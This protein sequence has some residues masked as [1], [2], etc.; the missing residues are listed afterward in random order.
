MVSTVQ[1][2]G[3]TPSLLPLAV[4]LMEWVWLQQDHVFSFL[5]ELLSRQLPSSLT[6]QLVDDIILSRA[7]VIKDIC[8]QKYV[9]YTV[10]SNTVDQEIFVELYFHISA[11]NFRHLASILHF[12]DEAQKD[13]LVCGMLVCACHGP[14]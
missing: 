12:V 1:A 6:Q 4:R 2:L 5:N 7:I 11:F 13:F 9:Y 10:R 8:Q 3:G 14:I